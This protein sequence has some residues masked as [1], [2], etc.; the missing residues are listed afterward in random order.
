[1]VASISSLASAS[2][3]ASYYEE[4]DYYTEG[5]LSPSNWAGKG[6]EALGL[7]G[8]VDRNQFKA[9]LEGQ[10][11]S[12]QLLGTVRSGEREHRPGYDITFSP[13]KSVSVMALVAGDER[14]IKA[15]D[16]AVSRALAFTERHGAETRIREGDGV[17]RE[18]TGNLLIATFCHQTSRERDPQLHTHAVILN[19]T[20][21]CKHIWRSLEGRPLFH[22]LRSISEIYHQELAQNVRQLGYQI[23]IG[24][25]SNFEIAGVPQTVL[26]AFS[27]RS[28]QIEAYLAERGKTRQ[29]AT[30]TEREIA[31]LSTRTAKV[32]GDRNELVA[33]W[34]K[35]ADALGFDQPARMKMVDEAKAQGSDPR[36]RLSMQ[37]E[38]QA[39]AARA[40]QFAADKLGERQSVIKLADLEKEAG[41]YA[42]GNVGQ[43][44]VRQAISKAEAAG[45]LT[46]RTYIERRGTESEGVTTKANIDNEQRLL[47]A[48]LRGRGVCAPLA[49]PYTAAKIVTQAAHA[50]EAKGQAWTTD[51]RE[52]T[53]ILLT[54]TAAIVGVQGFAGT[55]KT[56]TVLSTYAEAAH[57]AGFKIMA[58]APSASAAQTLGDALGLPAQTVARHLTVQEGE[59]ASR[60]DGQEIWLVDEASLLSAKDTARLL[61]AAEVNQS[62]VV[63]V[64]DTKQLGSVGAGAAFGQLQAAGMETAKLTEIVR[65]TNALTLEAVEASLAGQARKALDALDRGGG[66]VLNASTPEARRDLIAQTYAD[67]SAEERKRTLV[68]DP[69]REGREELTAAIRSALVERGDLGAQAVKFDAL[70]SKDL[71]K[72]EGK[73][74]TSFDIG[75]VVI[76]NKR[77]EAKGIE[78][79]SA[80]TVRG[81][82]DANGVVNL[83]AAN[84]RKLDWTPG[85]WG[86]ADAFIKAPQ[87][88]RAGDRIEFSRNDHA[89]GR[90][91]GGQAEVISVDNSS[92]SAKIRDHRGSSATLD[93]NST[94]DTHIRHAVVSTAYSAQGK[95]AD[96][97]IIHAESHRSNLIDQSTIYV[98]I[99]RARTEAVLVTDDR[100]KLI[101][102]LQERSGE[103]STA[104]EVGIKHNFGAE[105]GS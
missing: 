75:D 78:R 27:E 14:L 90:A 86:Q 92:Q 53:R 62:R 95:T 76:F 72:A 63:L 16:T 25:N 82:N 46:P 88:L 69:S 37:G 10:L 93:L 96:R 6:A 84:G 8:E 57:S 59:T 48:E 2:Q 18:R 26:T 97:V 34:R 91:N 42:V 61:T 66:R 9:L 79:G 12:G 30:A 3:A 31:A 29:T 89:A 73:L 4:D 45:E 28:A 39:F 80:F 21:D 71:T 44:E 68:I 56:T 65:Q 35:E 87:E 81:I 70:V 15:H 54:S 17:R 50:A 7:V 58:L 49:S 47:R 105:L 64:G 32:S 67:L 22:D 43:T 99:S 83:E 74:A 101:R 41:R 94:R 13:S 24:K 19:A 55:A 36:R 40:V 1:M 103:K 98:G 51:Q 100:D 11:P 102:G 52:A 5:G 60:K 77:L 85:Q 20:Q 38:A 23:E 104:I 33:E